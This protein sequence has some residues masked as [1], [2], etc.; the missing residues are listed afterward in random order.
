M[1]LVLASVMNMTFGIHLD[2]KNALKIYMTFKKNTLQLIQLHQV[3][4]IFNVCTY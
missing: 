2:S 4:H 3:I 1:F